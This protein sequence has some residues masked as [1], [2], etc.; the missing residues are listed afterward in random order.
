M[1]ASVLTAGEVRGRESGMNGFIAR[2]VDSGILLTTESV[3]LDHQCRRYHREA[4]RG[5]V[6]VTGARRVRGH[7][8]TTRPFDR[9]R[10]CGR[11]PMNR[12]WVA[13][14]GAVMLAAMAAQPGHAAD[15]KDFAGTWIIRSSTVA[16]WKGP[17]TPLGTSED[18]RLIGRTVTFADNAVTGPSPIGCAKPVYK[19]ATVGPD[20]IFEGQ[21]AE[22]RDGAVKPDPVATAKKLAFADPQHIATLDAGC[23]EL[24]FHL[25]KPGTL[26]FGLNNRVYLMTRK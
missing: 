3:W 16:P 2:A 6:A 10:A 7:S 12:Q 17:R 18:N 23:T 8:R 9:Q 19:V 11:S 13:A 5:F 1:T 20:M 24:Q 4:C 25:M 15:F 22:P 26:A 14:A 21:L